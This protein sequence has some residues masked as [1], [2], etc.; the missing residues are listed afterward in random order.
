M[1]SLRDVM[2]VGAGSAVGGVARLLLTNAASARAAGGGFPVGTLLVNVIGSLIFGVAV[3]YGA[4]R[5]ELSN[6]TRLMLTAGL[7][8]GFTTFSTFSFDI[9]DALEHGRS[10]MVTSYVMASL[11]L[12]VLAM[13]AGMSL[14]RSFT[15]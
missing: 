11:V 5:G 12:G 15:R 4:D 14:A 9:V 3:R 7:C 1:P 6:A 10:G 13:L 8:G 2:L